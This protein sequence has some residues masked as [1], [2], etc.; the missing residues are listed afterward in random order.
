MLVHGVLH[1]QGYDH[2]IETEAKEME[3]LEIHLL[4]ELGIANPYK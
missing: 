2:L 3:A 1:L 4:S